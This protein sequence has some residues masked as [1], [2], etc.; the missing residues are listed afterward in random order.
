MNQNPLV[1]ILL[2]AYNA[3]KFI[4]EAINSITNQTYNNLEIIVINDGSTDTTE[5]KVNNINDDRIKLINNEFNLGLIETLNKGIGFCNGK[6]IARMDA[7]DISYLDRIELQVQ[8]MEESD[9]FGICGTWFETFNKSQSSGVS[10]YKSSNDEIQIHLLYQIHLC[11]GTAMFRKEVFDYFKF[12][13]KYA[14]AEDFELWS[15]IKTIYK[16]TNIPK[17][18]YRVNRHGNNVSILNNDI[19]TKNT[20][21]IISKQLEDIL[22]YKISEDLIILYRNFCHADFDLNIT[23]ITLI[24]KLIKDLS[25]S[26]NSLNLDNPKAFVKYLS[27]KW[28]HLCY[29]NLKNIKNINTIWKQFS[30]I[31]PSLKLRAKFIIKEIILNKFIQA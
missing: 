27:N 22:Q 23:Q 5:E 10:K 17:V 11:H 2:P 26:D 29:N 25:N 12:D 21:R 14:H 13:K 28:E 15:R 6:Y 31:K 1:S 19:Q 9:E 3:E 8:K 24:G 7:D 4:I 20:L 30:P 16:M 18:L